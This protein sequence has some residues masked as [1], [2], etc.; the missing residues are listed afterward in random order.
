MATT[1]PLTTKLRAGPTVLAKLDEGELVAMTFAN[2]S[3]AQAAA[4][5]W[6]GWVWQSGRPFFVRFDNTLPASLIGRWY[7]TGPANR[8]FDGNDPAFNV[9]RVV[10]EPSDTPALVLVEKSAGQRFLVRRDLVEQIA[11]PED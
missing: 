7:A 5:K 11:A 2:R 1:N 8:P 10:A 3:Q 6:N 4:A 9:H